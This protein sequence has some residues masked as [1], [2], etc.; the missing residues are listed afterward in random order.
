MPH[1]LFGSYL[2]KFVH[3]LWMKHSSYQISEEQF[4]F[5][6]VS[7]CSTFS[8]DFVGEFAKKKIRKSNMSE[9]SIMVHIEFVMTLRI[10][11]SG[12]TCL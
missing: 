5:G 8:G 3:E 4:L 6:L 2:S 9:I 1:F 7:R 11:D 12:I 10:K